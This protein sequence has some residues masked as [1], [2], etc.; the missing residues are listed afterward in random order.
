LG[1]FTDNR[2]NLLNAIREK[3]RE[4]SFVPFVFDFEPPDTKNL[5]ETVRI[6]AGL[7]YFV[8]V[9]I[10]AP[11]SSPLEVQATI[12]EFM[13]PF[14]PIIQKGEKPF[15]MFNDLINSAKGVL[16]P[17]EYKNEN[18]LMKVFSKAIV[19]RAVKKAI[20]LNKEKTKKITTITTDDF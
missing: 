7:S 9:D 3:L 14:V 8:I 4:L 17:L 6:L 10:T 18:D 2:I 11:R 20:Q 1:R 13:I 5:T 19:E 12:P 15:A 16:A